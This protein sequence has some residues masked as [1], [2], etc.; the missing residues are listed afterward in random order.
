MD[1]APNIIK[2]YSKE[3]SSEER[4]E[5]A[6]EILEKRKEYRGLLE[7]KAKYES[8][9]NE[10]EQ[11]ETG[12]QERIDE[13]SGAFLGKTRNVF[14]LRRDKGELKGVQTQK[15]IAQKEIDRLTKAL[16]ELDYSFDKSEKRGTFI[17]EVHTL[18]RTFYEKEQQKWRNAPYNKEDIKRYFDPEYLATLSIEDY[19]ELMRRFPSQMV[20]HVTRQGVRDHTGHMYHTAG[21]GDHANGFEEIVSEGILRSPL[22]VYLKDGLTSK[23]IEK[24]L[25][26][27]QVETKEEALKIL[28]KIT[29][30][31]QLGGSY[32]DKNA[33]HFACEEV[34]D[35]YYGSET[36]N[37]I[38]IVFPSALVA[39]Q[40]FFQGEIHEGGSG[41]WN[42]KWVWDK[43]GKGMDINAGIVFIP[44]E[45]QVDPQTGSRYQIE[46]GKAEVNEDHVQQMQSFFDAPGF[47]ETAQKITEAMEKALY[48]TSGKKQRDLE[49][50]IEK[51]IRASLVRDFGVEDKR[52]QDA[53][54]DYKSLQV[55]LYRDTDDYETRKAVTIA[56]ALKKQGVYYREAAETVS[57]EEY[58]G[59]YFRTHADKKPSK[60]VYYKGTDPTKALREWNPAANKS[61]DPNI[62][63]PE[64][65]TEA[66]K[67]AVAI[68]GMDNFTSLARG[69]IDE[70]YRI[71]V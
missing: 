23:A 48:E 4:S 34:A 35:S 69:V 26:L 63:F 37:E 33:V 62:G 14:S 56:E 57:S 1:D 52:V 12:V 58:W 19:E 29:N 65:R 66:S 40:Y 24:I 45:A 64:R 2:Q 20:T 8:V 27:E 21:V 54:L 67:S 68:K 59:K 9:V 31:V 70:Y 38:F 61:E 18:L 32:A 10:F 60:I 50:D 71:A 16:Y 30:D 46:D 22:S 43:D 51:K 17:P 15:E 28:D 13:K 7:Q 55:H 49:K 47:I 6:R 25:Q 44:A 39:S 42:D 3:V 5:L 11:E 41:Y 53:I 36:G